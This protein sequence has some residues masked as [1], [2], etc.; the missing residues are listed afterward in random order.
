VSEV[1][2]DVTTVE[3]ASGK[4]MS[5]RPYGRELCKRARELMIKIDETKLDAKELDEIERALAE[6]L[7]AQ[8]KTRGTFQDKVWV[9]LIPRSRSQVDMG[10]LKLKYPD[11]W[12]DCQTE[13]SWVEVQ[14]I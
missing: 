4:P 6:V 5:L 13:V 12:R 11:V 9:Q 10:K 7:L 2:R 3:E 8:G 14:I 1:V